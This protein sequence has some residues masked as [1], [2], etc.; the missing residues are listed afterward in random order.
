MSV[1]SYFLKTGG[2]RLKKWLS[3]LVLSAAAEDPGL[4]ASIHR[5]DHNHL[6]LQSWG[7]GTLFWCP[8][9][10]RTHVVHIC[11][12]KHSYIDDKNK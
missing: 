5:V 10:P 11:A 8:Q 6:F 9:A 4:V 12:G 1:K 7:S 3:C 2:R